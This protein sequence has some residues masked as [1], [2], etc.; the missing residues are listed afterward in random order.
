M[1]DPTLS[2]RG[3]LQRQRT[4][5]PKM[6]WFGSPHQW[7]QFREVRMRGNPRPDGN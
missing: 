4:W 2:L 3:W 5:A 7:H 6:V 1:A